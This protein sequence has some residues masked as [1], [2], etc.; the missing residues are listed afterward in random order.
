MR[1]RWW[2]AGA[3]AVVL[4]ATAVH[5]MW[6]ENKDVWNEGSTHSGWRVVFDGYGGVRGSASG[7]RIE[8]RPNETTSASTTHGA[9]VASS[10]THAD[11]TFT[12]DVQTNEQL[13]RPS[14]NP[15]E[16]GWVLVRYQDRNHFYAFV[17]KP[18]GWEL[19]KQDPA[20]RGSQ[21]FLASGT[22]PTFQVG[23]RHRVRFEARGP[24]LT[25]TVDDRHLTTFTDTD[26]P[27]LTGGVALYT[28]DAHVTF[29]NPTVTP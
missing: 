18:N 21:R 12:V 15:W 25:I 8:L 19:S 17:P 9:L 13:R 4:I 5:Q 22:T 14:P 2:I 29:T 26:S 27:Y 6:P 23:D 10:D 28:E 24:T 11:V 1:R 20:F 16:V 3:V 7:D